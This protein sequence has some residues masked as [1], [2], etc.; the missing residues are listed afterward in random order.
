MNLIKLVAQVLLI[1]ILYRLVMNFVI[2]VFRSISRFRKNFDRM[3]QGMEQ[4][5]RQ[6]QQFNQQQN[7][8][9]P[10]KAKPVSSREGEYIE[11]EEIKPK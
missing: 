9:E 5:Y 7:M 3:Q 8:R 6:Q 10:E 1:Y 2:P 4:Q 11:F